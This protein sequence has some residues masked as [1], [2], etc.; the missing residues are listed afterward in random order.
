MSGELAMTMQAGAAMIGAAAVTPDALVQAG[1]TLTVGLLQSVL[2]VWG[3][4]RMGIASKARDRQLDNQERMLETLIA[5]MQETSAGL[6]DASVG[7]RDASAG[8]RDVSAGLR[9][10]IEQTVQGRN[11]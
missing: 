3:L 5:G 10:V 11:T 9:I 6:R 4:W 1:A 8:L 7:L 2:I